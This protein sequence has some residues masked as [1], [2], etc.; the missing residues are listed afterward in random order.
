MLYD[1]APITT[2]YI[3]HKN[4]LDKQFKHITLEKRQLIKGIN[5]NDR[6]IYNNQGTLILMILRKMFKLNLFR[7]I[8][9]YEYQLL[10]TCEFNNKL[11][12]Y[13]E[14]D[15]DKDLCTRIVENQNT[16]INKRR[17]Y[18]ADFETDVAASPHVPYLCCVLSKEKNKTF[19]KTFTGNNIANELL[20]YL[21]DDSITYFHNLKYDVCFFINTPGWHVDITERNGTVLKVVMQNYIGKKVNKNNKTLTFKNSYSIIPAPLCDFAQMFQLDVYK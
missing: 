14:L 20:N 5:K 6:P 21:I 1:N 16:F 10:E 2:Y 15:Y 8:N 3:T 11:N 13:K 17:I 9:A 12:D 4:K 7:E 18:Y 19:G